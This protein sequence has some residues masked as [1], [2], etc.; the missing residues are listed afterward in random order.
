VLCE[1]DRLADGLVVGVLNR[2]G[3]INVLTES[4]VV[5]ETKRDDGLAETVFL[6]LRLDVL[7][8]SEA[9]KLI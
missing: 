3:K 1:F 4:S 7:Q 2:Q 8:Y 6:V 9:G 5:W